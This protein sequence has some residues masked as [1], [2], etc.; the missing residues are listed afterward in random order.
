[1]NTKWYE[2]FIQERVEE[3]IIQHC[4]ENRKFNALFTI[5][6]QEIKF[7]DPSAAAAILEIEDLINANYSFVETAYRAGFMDGLTIAGEKAPCYRG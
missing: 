5:L 2:P 3:I 1:M 6:Y 4:K 7:R